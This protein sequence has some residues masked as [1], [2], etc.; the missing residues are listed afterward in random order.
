ML[1]ANERLEAGKLFARG[2]NDRLIVNRKLAAIDRLSE[3]VLEDLP[4][5]GFAM[6]RRLIKPM[7]ATAGGLGGIEGEIGVPDECVCARSAWVAD[8]IADRCPDR[9]LI[10]FD[11]IR[12]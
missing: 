9:D 2:A 11:L 10:A 7:L 6:H 5:G 1:P 4:F 12:L 3:I 8:G